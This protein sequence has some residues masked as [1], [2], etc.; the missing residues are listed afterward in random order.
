MA[1]YD[2]SVYWHSGL[3]HEGTNRMIELTKTQRNFKNLLWF[4]WSEL[5]HEMQQHGGD[6]EQIAR[7]CTAFYTYQ[8]YLARIGLHNDTSPYMFLYNFGVLP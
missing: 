4:R 5:L 7:F 8:G 2:G 1:R 6:D 3:C